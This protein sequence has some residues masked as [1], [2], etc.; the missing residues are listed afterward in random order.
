MVPIKVS[1][2][3]KFVELTMCVFYTENS[4]FVLCVSVIIRGLVQTEYYGAVRQQFVSGHSCCGDCITVAYYGSFV[5]RVDS[6]SC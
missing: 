6:D 2:A 3:S 4:P 1:C 5:N